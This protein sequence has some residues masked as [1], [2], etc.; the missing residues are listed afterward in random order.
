VVADPNFASMYATR[1]C[2]VKTDKRDARTLCEACGLGAY[3]PAH[4]TS[5]RQ[6]HVRAQHWKSFRPSQSC[7]FIIASFQASSEAEY[8][9][10]LIMVSE[11]YWL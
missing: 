9:L 8:P 2:K 11:V 7:G 10:N 5:D 1:S 3:R 4:R 6:R